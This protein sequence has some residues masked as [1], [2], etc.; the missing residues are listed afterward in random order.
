MKKIGILI[1]SIS[2]LFSCSS[3]DD[4]TPSQVHIRV[5]NVSQFDFQ[6]TVVNNTDY[7]NISSG[8]KTNY[9]TFEKAYSYL[10]VSLLIEG[11]TLSIQPRDLHGA[12]LLENGY[13]TYKIDTHKYQGQSGKLGLSPTLIKE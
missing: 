8:Q 3:N 2:I 10:S 1:I 12:T 4:I 11:D 6:H 9:K 5:A 7:G 13:Y